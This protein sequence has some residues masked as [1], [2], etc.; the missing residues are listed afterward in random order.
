MIA[1]LVDMVYTKRQVKIFLAHQE[2][3]EVLQ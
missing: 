1:Y 3:Q 2:Q